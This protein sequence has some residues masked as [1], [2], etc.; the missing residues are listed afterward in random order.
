MWCLL[1]SLS[2]FYPRPWLCA[3]NFNEILVNPKIGASRPRRQIEEFRSCLYDCQLID[4]G[5]SGYKYTWCNHRETPDT[6]RT[7]LDRACA[8][9]GWRTKF[10]NVN[11]EAVAAGGSDHN[12]LLINLEADKGPRHTQR[13][14]I[15]RFEA[16]WTLSEECEDVIKD[17]WCGEVEGD[18]GSRILQR[19]RRVQEKLIGWDRERF[20]HVKR[21][22]RELEEKLEAYA[23]DSSVLV[24]TQRG[25]H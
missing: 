13:H 19:T 3:G 11:V 12:P 22:V 23:K 6:V 4:L 25:G 5:Y 20:G 1:R 7:H 10:P 14:K 15:F 16:M 21:R 2:R 24:T 18:A 9:T 8:M 17:S